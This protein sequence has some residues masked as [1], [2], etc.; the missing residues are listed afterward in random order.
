[1][2]ESFIKIL[3]GVSMVHSGWLSVP[4]LDFRGYFN[5]DSEVIVLSMIILLTAKY[6]CIILSS[7]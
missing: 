2:K 4:N 7:F 6:S 3:H 1:M 5:L